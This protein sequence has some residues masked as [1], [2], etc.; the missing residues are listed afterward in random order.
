MNI[1]VV[2][3]NLGYYHGIA[4]TREGAEEVIDDMKSSGCINAFKIL[5]EEIE[6]PE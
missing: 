5:V 1:Y 3:D 4:M 2:V 6:A